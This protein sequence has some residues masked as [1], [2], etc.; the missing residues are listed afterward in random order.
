MTVKNSALSVLLAIMVGTCSLG[1]AQDVPQSISAGLQAYQAYHGGNIDQVNLS[2]GN[3]HVSIPLISY[4]QR[5]GKL[6]LSYALEFN[7]KPESVSPVCV[8]N[9]PNPPDCSQYAWMRPP[10]DSYSNWHIVDEQDLATTSHVMVYNNHGVRTTWTDMIWITPDGAQHPGAAVTS[11]SGQTGQVSLDGSGFYTGAPTTGTCSSHCFTSDSNGISYYP[12]SGIKREDSN[13]NW[14][15]V[16]SNGTVTD[17]M[18]R[19]IPPTPTTPQASNSNSSAG[20][21]GPLPIAAVTTWIVPGVNDAPLTY[22]FCY[23][24]IT[25]NIPENALTPPF[26]LGPPINGA[27]F[28][29]IVKL[30]SVVLPNSEGAWTFE[31]NSASPGDPAGTNYG[32]LSKITFPTGGTISYSYQLQNVVAPLSMWATS[33]TVVSGPSDPGATWNYKYGGGYGTNQ[34]AITVTDPQPYS[35]DTVHTFTNYGTGASPAYYETLTQSYNGSS[36]GGNVL[37]TV[38][39]TYSS[40]GAYGGNQGPQQGTQAWAFPMTVVTTL[41]GQVTETD[42]SYCCSFSA[43]WWAFGS[44][45]ETY[46]KVSDVKTYDFGTGSHGSLLQEKK[47][48]YQF[49][50]NNNFLVNNL[51]NAESAEDVYDGSGNHAADTSFSYDEPGYLTSSGLG[52]G[53]NLSSTILTGIR[54]NLTSTNHWLNGGS[55]PITHTN[56]YDDGEPYQLIDAKGATASTFTYSSS[57]YWAGMPTNVSDAKG[58]HVAYG[59][60]SAGLGVKTSATDENSQITTYS[61]DPTGRPTGVSYPDGGGSTTQYTDSGSDIGF[62]VTQKITSSSDTPPNLSKQTQVIVDG[63]G[64]LSQTILLSDPSGVTSTVTTYDALGRKYKVWNPTRCSTPTTNCGEST[65]GFTTYGYDALGRMNSQLDSDGASSQSWTYNGNLVTYQDE[66]G[67]K[68]QRTSDALGRLTQVL[69]PNGAS[70]APTMVTNY[71]YDALGDLTYVSQ[72]GG[73]SYNSSTAINRSFGYDTLSRLTQSYNP[74]SG[75]ICYGTTNLA[76]ANGLNCAPQYDANGNLMYK[77]DARGVQIH[78]SYD[79]LNRLTSKSYSAPSPAPAGYAATSP[80]TYNYDESAATYGNGRRTSMTDG[81]GAESWVYDPM[82]RIDY[83]TRSTVTPVS[84]QTNSAYL[85][86]NLAGLPTISTFFA[87]GSWATYTYAGDGR[88]TTLTWASSNQPYVT[89][90][91]YAPSGQLAA[92]TLGSGGTIRN[93]ITISKSYNNRLQPTNSTAGISAQSLFNHTLSYSPN[94]NNGNIANDADNLNAGN[95]ATY[96]YD[97]LNRLTRAQ[98]PGGGTISAW[99]ES[100]GFDTFG[101]LNAK[102]DV[103]GGSQL[104]FS[105]AANQNNQ[106]P[107]LLHYDLAGHVTV[108]NL[109][110][111]YTW[112]AEGRMASAGSVLYAYDGDGRRVLKSNSS[113][114]SLGSVYWYGPDGA[115]TDETTVALNGSNARDLQRNFYFDGKLIARQGFPTNFYP[116]DFIISDQLGSTRVAVDFSWN[117]PGTNPSPEY[118]NYFPFGGYLGT[119]ASDTIDE[120]FTGKVRDTETGNDYFGARN[121]T[122]NVGRFLSPDWSASP[123]PVPYANQGDPQ[124]LNLYEYV[125]NNP[126]S[127]IDPDG[128]LLTIY[129]LYSW[130]SGV[131]DQVGIEMAIE[132]DTQQEDLDRA[133]QHSGQSQSG[134][135]QNGSSVGGG[136]WSGVK[137]GF[138]NLFHGHLWNYVKTSVSAFIAKTWDAKDPNVTVVTDIAGAVGVAAPKISGK[139]RL[140]PLSA[141]ASLWNDHSLQ[142]LTWTGLGFTEAG[143]GLVPASLLVDYMQWVNP[144]GPEENIGWDFTIHK[145]MS[146][147]ELGIQRD[148][149]SRL[150]VQDGGCQAAGMDGPC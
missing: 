108:D 54:G 113:I 3:V 26:S 36:S 27:N 131:Q 63:L 21:T 81:A 138:S 65:W 64:R 20:C 51:L 75:W 66:A 28:H 30:Q 49:Q 14:I 132:G 99:N 86:H 56:W 29:Y 140:G 134:A 24:A 146:D 12:S 137:H 117:G 60:D 98:S 93:P 130:H 142:N 147:S 1:S 9:W 129:E 127:G 67:N 88:A 19:T 100:N 13:G 90:A 101:N 68:W 39:T 73:S 121:F 16:S 97:T 78:Y 69:E 105:A 128:H 59:Y 17:T 144:P 4:P 84:T 96:S 80:V 43:A 42:T 102:T 110:T 82:G 150:P 22:T 32:D 46:G 143:P 135:Q 139:L 85:P 23:V 72:W 120:K 136:F 149:A 35:N 83:M 71:T 38:A 25:V 107:S 7:G 53:Q 124:S 94:A 50:S 15:A 48:T 115:M 133:L 55:N 104:S 77:T 111:Q 47:T 52:T 61:F 18:G 58:F 33:R 148:G 74:E 106:L 123:R 70:T 109:G 37:K 34:I 92:M 31:Y 145:P 87:E 76:P 62:T 8:Q 91:T 116:S 2:N 40:G 45:T 44:G 126:V 11:V 141:G 57:V 95:V 41:N 79:S 6:K 112:D 118:I 114:S 89:G 103:Y 125:R 5:G 10:V 119:P 122:S